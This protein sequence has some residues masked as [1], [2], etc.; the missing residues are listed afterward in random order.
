QVPASALED[1]LAQVLGEQGAA[2]VR[3]AYEAN[4]ERATPETRSAVLDSLA[5]TGRETLGGGYTALF[6]T[7]PRELLLRYPG[8]LRL[9]VDAA[10]DS[11]MSLHAQVPGLDVVR[12]EGASH[13]LMLDRPEEFGLALKEFLDANPEL[14]S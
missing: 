5:A 10:N 9:I 2:F 8:P 6:A 3:E 13:W 4:L 11:P 14:P 7:D 12:I 1:F